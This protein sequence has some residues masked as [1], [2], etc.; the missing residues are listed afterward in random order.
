MEHNKKK[1]VCVSEWEREREK[2]RICLFR[3]IEDV[4]ENKPFGE[5][6]LMVEDLARSPIFRLVFLIFHFHPVLTIYS[7][8]V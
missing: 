6:T 4:H 1:N 3:G 8:C 2:V 5:S 7:Y